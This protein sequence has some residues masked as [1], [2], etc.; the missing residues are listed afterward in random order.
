MSQ[1][2]NRGTNYL[3]SI[4]PND[5]DR[6]T[7][8]HDWIL[9]EWLTKPKLLEFGAQ[10]FPIH[11][12][13]L[14]EIASL[15]VRTANRVASRLTDAQAN[16]IKEQEKLARLTKDSGFYSATIEKSRQE[17]SS[18]ETSMGYLNAW[19]GLGDPPAPQLTITAIRDAHP[20]YDGE[21]SRRPA[22]YIDRLVNFERSVELGVRDDD[23]TPAWGINSDQPAVA[24]EIKSRIPSYSELIQQLTTYRGFLGK[25][26]KIVVVCPDDKFKSAVEDQGFAFIKCPEP[27]KSTSAQEKLFE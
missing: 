9:L 24:F 25:K 6:K 18:L 3:Q 21:R 10:W 11:A 2:R 27:P 20:C 7:P 13:S 16:R 12:W 5:P 4:G 15:R 17:I 8:G 22:I 23:W 26:F 14:E 1:P 19:Q